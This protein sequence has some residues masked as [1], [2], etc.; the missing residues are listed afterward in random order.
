M[1]KNMQ[2]EV[3]KAVEATR[4]AV[5]ISK[6]A[7]GRYA[8]EELRLIGNEVAHA[9]VLVVKASGIRVASG[10]MLIN[11]EERL[12]HWQQQGVLK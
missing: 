5:A 3:S 1:A 8:I 6:G 2:Q 11:L 12:A 9:E 10:E 4:L 7:D